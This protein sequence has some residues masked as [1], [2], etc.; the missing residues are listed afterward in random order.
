MLEGNLFVFLSVRF[1][2]FKPVVVRDH[3]E[4]W[5]F[6]Q[7]SSLSCLRTSL[8]RQLSKRLRFD[9]SHYY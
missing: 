2:A 8:D 7:G 9:L 3:L 5:L 4:F 1:K 6:F